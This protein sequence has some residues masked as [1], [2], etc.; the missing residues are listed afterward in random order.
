MTSLAS[1]GR[2]ANSFSKRV[3]SGVVAR[4]FANSMPRRVELRAPP[5]NVLVIMVLCSFDTP[6]SKLNS[7]SLLIVLLGSDVTAIVG[8]FAFTAFL[9]AS[10]D[11]EV[12]PDRDS[13][14]RIEEETAAGPGAYHTNSDDGTA[15]ASSPRR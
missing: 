13:E 4:S 15:R 9:M 1:S 5:V 3:R 7:H 12:L 6:V 10:T 8:I 2:V 14:I 11:S